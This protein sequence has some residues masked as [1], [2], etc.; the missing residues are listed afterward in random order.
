MGGIGGDMSCCIAD[1]GPEVFTEEW[2]KARKVHRCCECRSKIEIDETYEY[3]K[4]LWDGHWSEYKTCEKCAD[5]RESLSEVTCPYYTGLAD[6]YAD[7]LLNW[8]YKVMAR[9]HAA[10][11]LPSWVV[12]E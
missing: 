1:D 3:I 8:N 7:Y 4:G 2:R 10:K 5:L 9:S 12:D 6:A 11:L